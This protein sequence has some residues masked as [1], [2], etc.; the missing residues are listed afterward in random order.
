MDYKKRDYYNI[1]TDGFKNYV[2]GKNPVV[3]F[4]D[5]TIGS[6][7]ALLDKPASTG[8]PDKID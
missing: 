3:K 6:L 7:Y 5:D 2:S 1:V 4:R 8:S